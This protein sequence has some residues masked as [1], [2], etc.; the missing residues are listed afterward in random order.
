M[1]VFGGVGVHMVF[2]AFI[3]IFRFNAIYVLSGPIGSNISVGSGNY[4]LENDK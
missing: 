3:A 4:Y 1:F 2:Q